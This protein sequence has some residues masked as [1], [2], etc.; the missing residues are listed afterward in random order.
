[1]NAPCLISDYS[2]TGVLTFPA[3]Q[4]SC[5]H[6]SAAQCFAL[7]TDADVYP[8]KILTRISIKLRLKGS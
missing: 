2:M 1:M 6:S 8:Y 3:V 5:M 4:H 7:E